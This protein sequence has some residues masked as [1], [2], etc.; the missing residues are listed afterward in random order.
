LLKKWY[1]DIADDKGNVYIGYRAS[2]KWGKFEINGFQHLRRTSAKGV[3]TQV[4]FTKDPAPKLE[5]PGRIIWQ[6][7]KVN[8]SWDSRS[9]PINETL[10]D[11]GNG[12]ITWQCFQPK[13]LASIVSP[14]LSFHGLG[15]VECID[16]T[17]PVWE[18]PFKTLYWGRCHTARH[19][20]VWIRWDGKT[21]QSLVWFDGKRSEDLVINDGIISGNDFKL[22]L[23]ENITLR[24]GV[25]ASTIFKAFSDIF[26][27]LPKPALSANE[28]KWYN[29]GI[30][31]TGS[32]SEP[33]VTIYEKV[34]W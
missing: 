19:Y 9:E 28:H 20:L 21:K 24:Q 23:G 33:A 2:L 12:K 1:L 25:I 11:A 17:I 15:Y 31:E 4:G 7:G 22:K 3:V 8:A 26:K 27:F 10:I 13:A 18:L 16:I 29:N 30:L 14:D 32:E 6:S 34:I 5:N